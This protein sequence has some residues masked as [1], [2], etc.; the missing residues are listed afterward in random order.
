LN[1]QSSRL[2]LSISET[3]IHYEIC[4]DDITSSFH[5]KLDYIFVDIQVARLFA[6]NILRSAFPNMD[7]VYLV[8]SDVDIWPIYGDAY[9]LPQG[10]DI[11]SLNSDCCQPFSHRGK[12]HR[13][14]PMANIGMKIQ[15]WR[16][17]TTKF[18]ESPASIDDIL[19][20]F[21]REFGTVALRSVRKGENIG[22]FLDQMMVSL[23]VTEWTEKYDRTRVKYVPRQTGIDRIDRNNWDLGS[24][25]EDKIDS[26][27]PLD[28]FIPGVWVRLNGL[29][30]AMYGNGSRRY[31]WCIDYYEQFQELFISKYR[32]GGIGG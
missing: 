8:T 4:I 12:K 23:L 30:R 3:K 28:T 5:N 20:F 29:I 19:T 2:A 17:M 26:H 14:L 16:S 25:I 22:W 10:A 9:V 24:T 11:L 31:R 21:V 7:D 18:G 27:L 15:T 6:G 13:M 32:H 1:E